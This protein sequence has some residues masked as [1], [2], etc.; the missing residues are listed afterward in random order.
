MLEQL[1]VQPGHRVL[2]IGAATGI[3]VALLAELVGPTGEVVTIE[4]DGALAAGARAGLAAA[5]YHH[6]E[7]SCADGAD[8]HPACAP[9]DRIIVTAGAWDLVSPWWQQLAVGGRMVVP[10]RLHGSGL[11]RSIAFDIQ[12]PGRMVSSSARVCGFVAM[13]GAAAHTERSLQLTDDIVLHL[14][15]ADLGDEARLG[16][17]LTH[18]AHEYWTGVQIRTGEPVE[19]LDLWLATTT[20]RFARLS[21]GS[22]ARERGLVNPALRWAGAAGLRRR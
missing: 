5:G 16:Q 20:P 21:V 7:V 15:A 12:Q 4:I 11:T 22:E 10:L 14:D 3:D 8:G 2:E 1:D 17:T 19:H 18:P 6:V 13:R 9:Y